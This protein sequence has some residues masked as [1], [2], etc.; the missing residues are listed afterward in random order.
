MPREFFP[1][2]GKRKDL[3]S[4]PTSRFKLESFSVSSVSL[5]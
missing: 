4:M 3:K 2:L 5:W 1:I